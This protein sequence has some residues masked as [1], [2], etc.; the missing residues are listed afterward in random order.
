MARAIGE[1]EVTLP[2]IGWQKWLQTF[3]Y[4]GLWYPPLN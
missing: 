2:N 3:V 4:H 1:H